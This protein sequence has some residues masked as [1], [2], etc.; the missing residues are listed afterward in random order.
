MIEKI[1]YKNKIL[2]I[3]LYANYRKKGINFFT[4]KSFSQQL[5]YMN[6]PK[7]YKIKPHLHK[8][9]SRKIEYTN[10]VLFIK[11]GIVRVDFYNNSKKYLKSKILKKNDVILLITGAHGFEMIRKSEI[12]EV[13][14]GPYLEENYDKT[15]FKSVDPDKVNIK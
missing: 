4:P 6:R 9:I 3:I 7:G 1:I 8:K 14:Q 10:E 2:A 13:K 12:I 15:R 11:S 5:G